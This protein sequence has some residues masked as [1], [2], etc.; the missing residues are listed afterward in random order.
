MR[1]CW[2]CWACAPPPLQ[3][4]QYAKNYVRL[5]SGGPLAPLP[6]RRRGNHPRSITKGAGPLVAPFRGPPGS[7]GTSPPPYGA[8]APPLRRANP[9]RQCAPQFPGLSVGPSST[10]LPPLRVPGPA[11]TP[12]MSA[13]KAEFFRLYKP[14]GEP[15]P[16]GRTMMLPRYEPN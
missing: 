16:R 15:Q 5:A 6:R 10:R 4:P 1:L 14:A 9:V 3:R 12:P 7:T 13:P 8:P 11:T 2:Q